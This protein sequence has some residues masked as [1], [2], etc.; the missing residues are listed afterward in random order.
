M[1]R[2]VLNH[3]HLI[4]KLSEGRSSSSGCHSRPDLSPGE[5]LPLRHNGDPDHSQLRLTPESRHMAPKFTPEVV[6]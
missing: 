4:P 5:P 1:Y 2:N 3:L 6:S